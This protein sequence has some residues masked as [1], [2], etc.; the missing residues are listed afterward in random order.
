VGRTLPLRHFSRRR[1]AILSPG[2]ESCYVLLAKPV[3][4]VLREWYRRNCLTLH[5]GM[6]VVVEPVRARLDGSPI[7]RGA[8]TRPDRPYRACERCVMD[9]TDAGIEFLEDDRGCNRC[10]KARTVGL[11]FRGI[12]SRA[13]LDEEAERI[14]SAAR[15]EPY[16][17][18]IGVSGGVDSSTCL[19]LAIEL[20]LRPLVVHVDA[21][22]NSSQAV[23]NVEQ[24][25]R[26]LDLDLETVVIE[27]EPLRRLQVAFLSAGVANQDTPQDHVLFGALYSVAQ[28]LGIRT[29]VEGTNWQTESI[30]PKSFGHTAKDAVQIRDIARRYGAGDLRALPILS[31]WRRGVHLPR[32]FG[33]RKFAPLNYV[34]YEPSS[35]KARLVADFGWLDYGEKHFESRWTQFFQRFL[36]PYRFGYD[37]RKAHL[38]SLIVSEQLTRDAASE[39][40][41]RPLHTP[42]GLAA[43]RDFVARKLGISE[44]ELVGLIEA[45]LRHYSEF[46]HHDRAVRRIKR[47]DS[48]VGELS[49]RRQR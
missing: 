39:I 36:L 24:L 15:G 46:R 26:R 8:F 44:Q 35:A 16:D 47:F 41:A 2:A 30:L 20:G 4:Q 6:A 40:L 34:E 29:V 19:V 42:E 17:C 14:R 3:V 43:D 32:V 22:W 38:S 28:R 49:I 13:L 18:L 1:T 5:W 31:E 11:R 12:S 25:C 37:K 21:G 23:Q 27:W 10:E 45:P 48:L 9:T 33:L 7:T